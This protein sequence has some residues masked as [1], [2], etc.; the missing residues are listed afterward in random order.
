MTENHLFSL[1]KPGVVKRFTITASGNNEISAQ[2]LKNWISRFRGLS[3]VQVSEIPIIL[4]LLLES[5]THGVGTPIINFKRG[6][7][8][9]TGVDLVETGKYG[10]ALIANRPIT[11]GET[12]SA[13]D[14]RIVRHPS[15]SIVTLPNDYPELFGRHAIQIAKDKW[16]DSIG[17]DYISIARYASH[18]CDPN[19][20]IKN[21][22]YIVAMRDIQ[23]G[24]EITWDYA[25]TE[26]P[27]AD[28]FAMQCLC[29]APACRRVI[30]GYRHLPEDFRTRYEGFISAWLTKEIDKR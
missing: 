20:G 21:R 13:F 5:V 30:K 23:P 25:M 22:N 6:P 4:V 18:S 26:N 24:Q 14:G 9:N 10:K 1:V 3:D 2:D 17:S 11:S 27:E 28:D 15:S 16:Q 12:I 8:D 19:C 29:G 7:H